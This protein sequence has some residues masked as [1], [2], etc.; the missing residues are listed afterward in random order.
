MTHLEPLLKHGEADE[1]VNQVREKRA[2]HQEWSQLGVREVRI[3]AAALR[4]PATARRQERTHVQ[5][6]AATRFTSGVGYQPVNVAK[7]DWP[8]TEAKAAGRSRRN[9]ARTLHTAPYAIT[10]EAASFLL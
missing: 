9:G 4:W 7:P 3:A 6:L 2:K 5:R 8:A 10:A 1:R